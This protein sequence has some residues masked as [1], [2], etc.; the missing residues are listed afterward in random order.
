MGYRLQGEGMRDEGWT[1]REDLPMIT[2]Q[3]APL[4]RQLNTLVKEG[5]VMDYPP[6][7]DPQE[8]ARTAQFV[9]HSH[10]PSSFGSPGLTFALASK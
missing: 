10:L 7:V 9:C 8:G 2:K 3:E 6:L 1:T 4:T 5:Y